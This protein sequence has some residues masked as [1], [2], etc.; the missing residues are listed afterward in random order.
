[1]HV[2]KV[3][4]ANFIQFDIDVGNKQKIQKDKV[5]VITGHFL[6]YE[7]SYAEMK[8]MIP[9][10]TGAVKISLCSEEHSIHTSQ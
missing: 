2:H 5:A 7:G 10:K 3:A 4:S 9:S 8:N 1:M 6:E